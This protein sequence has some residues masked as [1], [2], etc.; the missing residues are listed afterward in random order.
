VDSLEGRTAVIT[1]AASG[2]GLGLAIR[3][4]E[5]GMKVVMADIE[6]EPLEVAAEGLRAQGS[7]VLAV[8]TDVSDGDQVDALAAEAVDRFG[9][10]HVLCNNAGVGNS[11]TIA[12][13][14]SAD[15]SWVLGVNLWGVIHGLRAFLPGM[16]AHGETG[17]VVNT[18]SMAGLFAAPTM[19]P[20]CASKFAVVAIS[21]TLQQEM[22]MSASLIGV[23]VLCPGVVSTRIH[24]AERNRP[25]RQSDI[26]YDPASRFGIDP[27]GN[28]GAVG[29]PLD[30]MAVAEQV[31]GAIM[32]GRFYIITHP[33]WLGGV[34]TR[35]TAILEDRNPLMFG[36]PATSDRAPGTG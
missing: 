31:H 1:G 5:A 34:S 27:A 23:S 28:A 2:I 36:G 16:L 32:E 26:V 33:D 4:A 11:K 3:F 20:Y 12:T 13:L 22:A 29:N 9:P 17:H 35:M 24:Q 30:P 10:V 25:G 14:T 15:W 8:P 7:E 6:K 19:G 18:S 21:E